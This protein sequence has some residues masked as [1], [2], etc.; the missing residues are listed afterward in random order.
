M[1]PLL[2]F[3]LDPGQQPA[4]GYAFEVPPVDRSPLDRG[5]GASCIGVRILASARP[6]AGEVE[7]LAVVAREIFRP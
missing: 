6:E 3:L 1:Q 2:G 5:Y 4:T 7:V